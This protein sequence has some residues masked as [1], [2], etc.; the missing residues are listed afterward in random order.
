MK[1]KLLFLLFTVNIV[2]SQKQIATQSHAWVMYFGNHRFTDKWGIHTE[3]QWRRN[4]FF[5]NWQQSL[6][7]IG[8]DYYGEN[9]IQYTAGYAWI[10]TYEYGSQPVAKSFI[11]HRIWQQLILKNK[12]DRIEFQHRYR[13]EQRFLENWVK[14]SD[15]NFKQDGFNFRQ[16]VRYRFM[17][18][19]PLSRK[20]MADNTLFLSLYDEVF[21]G[22]GKGIGKNVLDQNR[23]SASLGWRFNKNFNVQLG[24]LNQ[25]MIKTDG[26]KQERNHTLQF[27]ITYNLDFRKAKK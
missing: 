17:A 4:D 19:I 26:I 7:R 25:Y 10:D 22:F 5:E 24:Y 21:I 20:E 16:R 18:T 23:I 27:G 15:G 3:Y 13:T 9:G 14:D 6:I 12:F 8:L 2:F 11:E 1:I